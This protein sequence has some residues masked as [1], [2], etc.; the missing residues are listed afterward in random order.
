MV[1]LAAEEQQQRCEASGEV[2][3][4]PPLQLRKTRK[5]LKKGKPVLV[6]VTT[7]EV[8]VG[9]QR[10]GLAVVLLHLWRADDAV[11]DIENERRNAGRRH[12]VL[13]VDLDWGGAPAGGGQARDNT[14]TRSGDK[15]HRNPGR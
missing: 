3:A 11:S 4:E 2:E 9:Y 8:R 14:G 10:H 13:I 12:P 5:N 7:D 6:S 15:R 1:A